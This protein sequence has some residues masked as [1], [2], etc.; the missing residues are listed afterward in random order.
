M[1]SFASR[2]AG[3]RKFDGLLVAAAEFCGIVRASYLS[4]SF[5]FLL[6]F[7]LWQYLRRHLQKINPS[8]PRG[9]SHRPRWKQTS[10]TARFPSLLRLVRATAFAVTLM[11]PAEGWAQVQVAS[12]LPPLPAT[13]DPQQGNA[14]AQQDGTSSSNG[15]LSPQATVKT[16][17]T[18][19][20][21][22]KQE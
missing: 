17:V 20:D 5:P 21:V 9:N 3:I 18:S 7:E 6:C 16:G 13:P 1:A 15:P 2:L 11:L 10:S 12:G 14:A 8:R 22:L 4:P 19:A